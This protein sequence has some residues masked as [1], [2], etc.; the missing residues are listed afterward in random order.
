MVVAAQAFEKL[1]NVMLQSRQAP[2]T[3][4]IVLKG[5]PEYMDVPTLADVADRT[6]DEAVRRLTSGRGGVE[7]VLE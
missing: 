6:L 3:L 4:A 7:H 5:N 1:L 2:Q